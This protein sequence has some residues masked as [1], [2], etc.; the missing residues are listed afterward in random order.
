MT[1]IFHDFALVIQSQHM[2]DF[3][4]V[5]CA[6]VQRDGGILPGLRPNSTALTF[7]S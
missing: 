7:G 1:F 2:T 3:K 4:P 6:L 5:A